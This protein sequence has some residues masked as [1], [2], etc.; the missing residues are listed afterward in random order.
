MLILFSKIKIFNF[1]HRK[2]LSE[3]DLEEIVNNSEDSD[4]SNDNNQSCD[5]DM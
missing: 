4:F 2:Q 5:S 3:E 1:S